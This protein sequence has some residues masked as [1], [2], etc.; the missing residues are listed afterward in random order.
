[1]FL[2]KFISFGYQLASIKAIIMGYKNLSPRG[3]FVVIY[4]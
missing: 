1:M 2:V 3:K 4:K